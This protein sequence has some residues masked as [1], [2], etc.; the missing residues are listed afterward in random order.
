M[1][2]RYV[3]SIS[4]ADLLLLGANRH[5]ALPGNY[6]VDLFGVAMMMRPD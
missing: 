1:T 2:G 6:V 4:R 5:Y 3:N